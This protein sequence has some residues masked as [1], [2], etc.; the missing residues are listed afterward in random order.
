MSGI[1][2]AILEPGGREYAPPSEGVRIVEY[3]RFPRSGPDAGPRLAFARD[4][5]ATGLCIGCEEPEPLG[6]AL[7]LA[8][9]A[10]DGRPCPAR[11]VRVVWC[12]PAGDGRYWLGL[13]D[14]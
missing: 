11:L 3:S 5:S 14:L 1:L 10:L 2:D 8:V 13:E 4:V 9:R 6:A 12:E 7:R